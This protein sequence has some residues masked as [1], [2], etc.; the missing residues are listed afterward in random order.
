MRNES[1]SVL[2]YSSQG[3][4][5]DFNK[6]NQSLGPCKRLTFRQKCIYRKSSP[7]LLQPK[8]ISMLNL[9]S[10]GTENSAELKHEMI[11][12]KVAF[13]ICSRSSG[14]KVGLKDKKKPFPSDFGSKKSFSDD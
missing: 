4:P 5:I 2:S 6:L 12:W 3:I 7:I 10:K 8:E 13:L 14:Q 1:D 9:G 11:P